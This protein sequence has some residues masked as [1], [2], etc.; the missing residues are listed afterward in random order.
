M[1]K[2]ILAFTLL[3]S[4]AFAGDGKEFFDNM[5]K[6]INE[7]NKEEDTKKTQFFAD[8]SNEIKQ[9]TGDILDSNISDSLKIENLQK[10]VE[11]I[12]FDDNFTKE[13]AN[14]NLIGHKK[15]FIIMGYDARNHKEI[16]AAGNTYDRDNREVQFQI[17]I[18]TP[19]YKNFLGSGGTLY[20]A[21]TQNSY[22][23]VFDTD[24][25]SP[26][27]ET[28]YAPEAFIDW[29]MDKKFGSSTLTKVRATFTHQSNGQDLPNSRSWNRNDLMA[30]FKNDQYYYGATIWNRWNEDAKTSSTS[31]KGDD[32]PDLEKFIGKQKYFV[33]YV[34]GD[35]SVELSHQNDILDYNINYG[36]TIVDIS[37]PS[38]N[39]NFD[40]MIRF[41]NGYGESLIDYNEKVNKI[42]FGIL[43]TDWI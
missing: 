1:K 35:Y 24:H 41:F 28:N 13:E 38:F 19:L 31:T 17:S 6:N 2:I 26:F 33:K 40:F 39:R 25:S 3:A 16:D 43:L 18:K 22:W 11:N 36:N 20:G 29:D 12:K 21:Y 5:A 34:D 30:V 4:L 10:Y 8:L 14:F 42:S 15:N 9:M 32:N 23:Q 7:K 37:F 27:R